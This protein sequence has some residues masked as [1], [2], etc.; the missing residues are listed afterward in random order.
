MVENW[1]K[2]WLL[3]SNKLQV[4]KVWDGEGWK[5]LDSGINS[6]EVDIVVF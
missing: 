1:Y 3:V 5:A 4:S 2:R 6:E